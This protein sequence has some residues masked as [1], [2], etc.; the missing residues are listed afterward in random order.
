[1]S[2][3]IEFG[4]F[5]LCATCVEYSTAP[6]EY[7][8]K[9]QLVFCMHRIQC[10]NYVC[11]HGP[12]KPVFSVILT[13]MPRSKQRLGIWERLAACRAIVFYTIIFDVWM[14]C[15][16]HKTNLSRLKY[17]LYSEH[18]KCDVWTGPNV[19]ILSKFGLYYRKADLRVS[20]VTALRKNSDASMDFENKNPFES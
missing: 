17:E 13:Q 11:L 20:K 1:M 18:E 5:E 3:T 2:G 12:V 4:R 9:V 15:M 6:V 8:A 14:K 19:F 7:S 10:I 16:S